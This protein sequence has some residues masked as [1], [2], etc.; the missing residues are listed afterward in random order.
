DIALDTA[1][2]NGTTTTCEALWMGVPVITLAGT[3]HASRVGCS[4]L[5]S[6]GLDQ[7]VAMDEEAFV[8]IARGLASDAGALNELRMSIRAKMEASPLRDEA[9][10]A[11]RFGEA[12]ESMWE[13]SMAAKA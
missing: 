5:R 8:S 4:L 13:K 10:F 1:P 9:G 6:V 2:Y 11:T 12:V 3:R 7:L